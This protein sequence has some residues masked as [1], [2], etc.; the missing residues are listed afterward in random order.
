MRAQG[1]EY[2]LGANSTVYH[3]LDLAL[4]LAEHT[5]GGELEIFGTDNETV[6]R[7]AFY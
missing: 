5:L 4:L 7:I 3:G 2:R 6:A 1:H